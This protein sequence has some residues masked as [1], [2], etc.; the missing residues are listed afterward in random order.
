M[1]D[2]QWNELRL[3]PEFNVEAFWLG[4]VEDLF[5]TMV[6]DPPGFVAVSTEQPLK[7]SSAKALFAG[8]PYELFSGLAVYRQDSLDFPPRIIFLY[9]G[10][11]RQV[12]DP[13]AGGTSV[14]DAAERVDGIALWAM[15]VQY[16]TSMPRQ[17]PTT[18]FADAFAKQFGA[19]PGGGNGKQPVPVTPVT[20]TPGFRWPSSET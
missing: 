9:W 10:Q 14:I 17:L 15:D 3:P 19:T 13:D 5:K 7:L 18:S 2:F 20:P 12:G 8:T 16:G 11:R 1:S 4:P 6:V